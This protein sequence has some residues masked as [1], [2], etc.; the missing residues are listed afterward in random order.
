[1]SLMP[2]AE[3]MTAKQFM[4]LPETDSSRWTELIEGEIVVNDPDAFHGLVVTNLLFALVAWS[5]AEPGRGYAVVPR[6]T[7]VDQR[8]V[9]KP[10]VLWCAR[11]LADP[12]ARPPYPMPDLAVEVRS[13]STWR[14]NLG[15]KKTRYEQHGLTEL[16]LVDTVARSVLVF[17]RSAPRAAGFDVA[18]EFESGDQVT[19]PQ[20]PGFALPVDAAFAIH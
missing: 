16:W 15:V 9:F 12:H 11:P 17:R 1:M 14:Y 19:S 7:E 10:D 5:R 2:V 8:N 6:D 20:L 18:L 3:K 13:R 4:A